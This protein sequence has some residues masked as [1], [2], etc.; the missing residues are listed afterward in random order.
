ME[1][2]ETAV[3]NQG[4]TEEWIKILNRYGFTACW[5]RNTSADSGEPCLTVRGDRNAG[6]H[7]ETATVD[8]FGNARLFARN[9]QLVGKVEFLRWIG[10]SPAR[11]T[12]GGPQQELP[13]MV[14]MELQPDDAQAAASDLQALVDYACGSTGMTGQTLARAVR[15]GLELLGKLKDGLK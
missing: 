1:A 10:N 13:G 8:I 15:G 11:Q 4:K 5:E 12:A 7:T 9:G 6:T 14:R 2:M 3:L